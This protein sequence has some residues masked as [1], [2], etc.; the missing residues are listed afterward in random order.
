MNEVISQCGKSIRRHVSKFSHI[1]HYLWL[2]KLQRLSRVINVTTVNGVFG[3]NRTMEHM[4][5]PQVPRITSAQ[6]S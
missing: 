3:V 5:S 6:T 1:S 4:T 2:L